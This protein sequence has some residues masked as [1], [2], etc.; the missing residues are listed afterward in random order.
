MAFKTTKRSSISLESPEAMFYDIKGR[1][2]EGLLSQ[3]ADILRDYTASAVN[4]ADVAL[5]LPT[6]SGKTLIGLLIAEW[7]R[8]RFEERSVY[9]CPTKQLVNQVTSYSNETYG[10][11]AYAFTGSQ[12]AFDPGAAA[13]WQA[14]E[15]VGITTYSSLFNINPFFD[16][17]HLITL[18][19]IHAAED[20]IADHWTIEIE[21]SQHES[22]YNAI[23]S[24]LRPTL[25]STDY[26]RLHHAPTSLWDYN[27]VDV[28][29]LPLLYDRIPE[30][31]ETLEE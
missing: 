14:G 4:A 8:R 26:M 24:V 2:I 17:P 16:N 18:D 23:S 28:V 12:R 21:R 27:W 7:R 13:Q 11:R 29:P 1:K 5:Q 25:S 3:Q 6:G 30:L 10:I 19:D 9:L 31:V 20:Y 22:V 15:V